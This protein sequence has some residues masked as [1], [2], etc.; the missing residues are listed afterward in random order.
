MPFYVSVQDWVSCLKFLQC[1]PSRTL[2]YQLLIY[3][4]TEAA[5]KTLEK[6]KDFFVSSI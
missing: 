2:L 6:S 3:L 4:S 5:K 1:C